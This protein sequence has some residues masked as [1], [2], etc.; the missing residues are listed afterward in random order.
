[1]A[2]IIVGVK[3]VT[4]TC[5]KEMKRLGSIFSPEYYSTTYL[6]SDCKKA[7]NVIDL[8]EEEVKRLMHND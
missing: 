6:C 8:P 7:V 5:G 4:C 2:S 3:S 1:M